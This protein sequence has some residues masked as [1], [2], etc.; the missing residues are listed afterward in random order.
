MPTAYYTHPVCVLHDPGPGH[1]EA[2]AR[3]T[4]V[5]DAL[6]ISEF[7]ALHRFEAPEAAPEQLQLMH[8][9]AYVASV[10]EAVPEQGYISLDPDTA[11]CPASGEAALR[12]A[13]G[14]CAAIDAVL[15][16]DV[17]N[18]FC[19]LR[20]PGHHAERRR[21]MGFCLFNNVAIAAGHAQSAHGIERVAVVDFDVHHGNGTQHMFEN[22]ES[23]F[24]A[25]SHQWPAYPGTGAASETGVG[26]IVNM[27]LSPGAG[28][29]AFRAAYR[30]VILPRLREFEPEL[31]LISA[32]FDAHQR[33]PLCQLNVTTADFAWLSQALMKV[34]AEYCSGRLVSSLEG[35][36]DLQALAECASAHVQALLG[37][38]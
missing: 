14:I 17:E 38:A 11:L 18:A 15:A 26:N 27:P 7:D 21:A 25:S 28:S 4:A 3:L 10:L 29:D 19:A 34:A 30:D 22:D 5:N 23:L 24:Y 32:G 35:G 36:Y 37:D 9:A 33:D 12:A 8:D 2:P 6:A 20:P 1:P 13:G 31:L 16:G